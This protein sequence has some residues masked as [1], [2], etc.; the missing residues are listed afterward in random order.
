MRP[1]FIYTLFIL[2]A[3]LFSVESLQA[4][5]PVKLENPM[6]VQY[7]KS[8]LRK[9]SPRL[10]LNSSIERELKKDLKND[11]VIKNMF[12]ALKLNAAEIMEQPLLTRNVIGRRLLGTSRE[13]LYRMN[14]LGMVYRLEPDAKILERIDDEVLAVCAFS[15]WNPSHYLDVAE[16]SMAVAF[17]VDWVG[18]DLPATTVEKA[19]AALIELG[20]MP[21]YNKEGNVGW[22]N[23]NNNWNQVCHGGMIAASIVIAEKDPEL[24]AKTI[25]RALEGMPHALE[26]YGPDGVYPEGSTYWGYGTSFTVLTAAM[27]ES[28]FGTDF[29]LANYPALKE[30]ADFRLWSNAPSGWYFNFADCGDRRSE[31]GDITLAWFGTKTGNSIYFERER[32]LRDPK[33]MG[34]LARYAGA[35]LVWLSQFKETTKKELPEAWKGGGDNPVVFFRGSGANTRQYYFGGKG[36]RG[37]VNHGNMD[38]GSFVFELDGVRWVVDPGNQSYHELEK[39]GFNLW[40][41][42]Q[43]CERWT[44][45]TKNNYGHSTIT[46]ND[47]LHNVDGYSDFIDFKAGSQPQATID[48]TEVFGDLEKITRTYAKPNDY[49]LLIEDNLELKESAKSITWQLMTT[50]EVES[51]KEG[52]LLK[53]DGKTLVVKN[54][55]HPGIKF[56]VISL[57]PPPLELDRRIENLKRIELRIPAYLFENKTGKISV[58]LSG[59]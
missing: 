49:S 29:G 19:K 36:G 16:M 57:D 18:S 3:I 54:Q 40:G 44:L 56:S 1:N 30:S 23:G 50:A 58:L 47:A 52:V 38:V 26:E 55:S 14:T 12:E 20:I 4:A 25:S 2:C 5:D 43:E 7:L 48:M 22:I 21:S 9:S 13:M 15:D 46:V 53:Q 6:T 41:R 33:E 27:F 31:N 34:E 8:K 35:G 24:A 32:F 39:T 28:A 45:L 10:V 59:E 51:T 42:C 11:P 37:S 17:A